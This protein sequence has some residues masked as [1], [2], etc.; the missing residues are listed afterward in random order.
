MMKRMMQASE[1]ELQKQVL[2]MEVE[3]PE[4]YESLKLENRVTSPVQ[5]TIGILVSNRIEHIRNVMEALQPLL[6]AVPSELIA[7][8]TK[9]ADSDGSIDIVREY[10]DKIYPFTWCN[11]FSAARNVCLD[12]AR[13]EWFMFLDDDEVFDDVQELIDFFQSGDYRNYESGYYYVRNYVGGGDYSMGIVG[14]MIHRMETTRFVGKVHEHFNEIYEPHKVFSCF[15]HHY[16]YDFKND[17]EL[18][19]HQ[20]RNVTLLRQE[21]KEHGMTPHICA[22][23]VQELYVC[24]DTREAGFKFCVNSMETLKAKGLLR[25]GCSQWLLV[26]SVRYYKRKKDYQGILRQAQMVREQYPMSQMAQ[27]A[28]AGIVVETSAPEGNVQAILEYAPLYLEAW[29]WLNAHPKEAIVQDTLDLSNYRLEEYAIQ[30]FQAAATCANA[31]KDYELANRYWAKLPWDNPEFDGAPYQMEYQKTQAGL[32]QQAQ[33]SDMVF[34][35]LVQNGWGSSSIG[36]RILMQPSQPSPKVEE[37]KVLLEMFSVLDEARP[38]VHSLLENGQNA[39]TVELLATMQE[40]IISLGNKTEQI[41]GETEA[42]ANIIS[43]L[44]QCCE[45]LWQCANTEGEEAVELFDEVEQGLKEVQGQL[46]EDCV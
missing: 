18:K 21:L 44:E 40:L 3:H 5:L 46:K 42:T 15:V 27:L 12:H 25:D 45:K 20:I 41:Y 14:R 4:L 23:M 6:K 7:V 38:V 19:K 43:V 9:G 17:E 13:G 36:Q 37:R 8:D 10:T 11:D 26:A 30:V 1:E 35:S 34:A 2:E 28:L 39:Q 29:D 24:E 32:K 31:V 33:L 22:Q 16:G